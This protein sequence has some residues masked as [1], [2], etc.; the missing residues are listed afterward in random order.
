MKRWVALLAFLAVVG[1]SAAAFGLGEAVDAAT[2]RRFDQGFSAFTA[3]HPV[4]APLAYT[5]AYAAAVFGS[6]PAGAL[7][8]VAGGYLFGWLEGAVYTLIAQMTGA[9]ALFLIARK[10]RGGWVAKRTRPHLRSVRNGFR[11]N[12][13]SYLIAMRMVG[14]LPA[15]LVSAV[16]GAL[17][18]PLRTYLLGSVL[19]LVPGTIVYAGIG[20]GLSSLVAAEEALSPQNV[21]TPEIVVGLVGL[22]VLALL[23]VVYRKIQAHR[24]A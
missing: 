8:T 21:F 11:R 23:P 10:A 9:T 22:I 17:G 16:P 12:A 6:V 2:L 18:V 13:L 3:A 1:A 24:H 7:L 4:L 5:L 14:V 20:A 19:G 15:F